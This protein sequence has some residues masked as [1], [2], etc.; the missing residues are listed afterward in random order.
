[1]SGIYLHVP[2]CK[3]ACSYCDFY[4]ITRSQFIPKYVD[5]LIGQISQLGDSEFSDE[6]F[7]TLYIGGGTPSRLSSEHWKHIFEALHSAFDI[8]EIAECTMEVN[9]D[10]VSADYLEKLYDSGVNR[11]SM[12]VQSFNQDLLDLMHRAHNAREAEKALELIQESPFENF[13]VDLIYG[14]P[15]ETDDVLESDIETLLS[16]HPPHVS[17]Y[18]LTIEPKT[19]L[20]KLYEKGRLLLPEDDQVVR[21]ASVVQQKLEKSGIQRYEV[22]NYARPGLEAVHNASYWKHDNYLGLGPGA[23]SF[24]WENDRK[25]A[26][27]WINKADVKSFIDHPMKKTEEELLDLES[28]AEEYIMMR[29]RTVAGLD[30]V[31]LRERYDYLLSES[32]KKYL[33]RAEENGLVLKAG[34]VVQVTRRGFDVADRL[35]LDIITA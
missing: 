10:D 5:G 11:L 27:R 30:L 9:P 28:L 17:A 13:T 21:Q 15:G 19:R 2:F 12:G 18:A 35:T 6:A 1:M 26:R 24:W 29:L 14:N 20:G 16:F 3:Q 8:S 31:Q 7:S 22:S 33:K 34:N 32:Q 4:F 25:L 23:H